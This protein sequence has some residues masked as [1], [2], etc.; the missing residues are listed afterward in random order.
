[1]TADLVTRL[2]AV[3]DAA[4]PLAIAVSG[5]VD[6]MTLG[7]LAGRRAGTAPL[8][9][10][11]V[12]PA[13]PPEAT[14]RVRRHAALEH[15][16]LCVGDAGEFADPTY[17]ANPVDRCFYCKTSLYGFIAG[18]TDRRIASGTNLDD[19]GDYR[20]GLRAADDHDVLHP[21]VEAGMTK[22]MVRAL[23]RA[24]ALTDI[25]E[26]PAAPC[27]ASRI[28]T[29]LAVTEPR[30]TFVHLIERE[31]QQALSPA[32]VR[33][34]IFPSGVVVQ[35]DPAALARVSDSLGASLTKLCSAHGYRQ[36]L[37]FLPYR[38]GSAFLHRGTP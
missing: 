24:L 17:R 19:L 35:L 22:A 5:G 30:L 13:V 3:L 7:V 12:S 16:E 11:A 27:L 23:A 33:C 26:L 10:H 28:A 6:S 32:V 4:G 14:A 20:P 8:I 29:G 1:M 31:V 2:L 21:Y 15:W 9:V 18:L 25:A 34:R 38:Q 36:A 37:R